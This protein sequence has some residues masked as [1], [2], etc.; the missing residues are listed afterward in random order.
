[1][2]LYLTFIPKRSDASADGG[3]EMMASQTAESL[4]M[5]RTH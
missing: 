3:A 2:K 4:S 1:M 5:Y